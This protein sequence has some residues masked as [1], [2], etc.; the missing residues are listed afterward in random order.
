[1][2]VKKYDYPYSDRFYNKMLSELSNK[3]NEY[4]KKLNKCNDKEVAELIFNEAKDVYYDGA[5]STYLRNQVDYVLDNQEEFKEWYIDEIEYLKVE[6][7]EI[8]DRIVYFYNGK[9]KE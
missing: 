9:F 5:V 1:M 4:I 8:F 7:T 2:K 6:H 3:I